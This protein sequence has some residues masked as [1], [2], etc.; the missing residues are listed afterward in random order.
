VF[1]GRWRCGTEEETRRTALAN[2]TEVTDPITSGETVE[3]MVAGQ[4]PLSGSVGYVLPEEKTIQVV[5]SSPRGRWSLLVPDSWTVRRDG[6]WRLE[7]P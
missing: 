3:V 4:Y 1:S 7:I 2:V 6:V 5:I